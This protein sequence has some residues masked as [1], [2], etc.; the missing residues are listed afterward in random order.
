MPERPTQYK[1]KNLDSKICISRLNTPFT[2]TKITC[3]F[4]NKQEKIHVILVDNAP[5]ESLLAK[6]IKPSYQLIIDDI[7]EITF[8]KNRV[9]PSLKDGTTQELPYYLDLNNETIEYSH[10][11]CSIIVVDKGMELIAKDPNNNCIFVLQ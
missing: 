11:D 7:N 3:I 9:K 8:D 10:P 6:S 2:S 1:P 5:P 4:L